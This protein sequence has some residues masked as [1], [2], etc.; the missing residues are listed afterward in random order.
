MK[1]KVLQNSYSDLLKERDLDPKEEFLTKLDSPHQID[2]LQVYRD[3]SLEVQ[4]KSLIATFR[5]TY[6]YLEDE[7]FRALSRDYLK[8][9]YSDK[10]LELNFLGKNLPAFI[11]QNK[12][13][14]DIL[15]LYETACVDW[16]CHLIFYGEDI[17]CALVSLAQLEHLCVRENNE[18]VT[19]TGNDDL[20]D[21]VS[22]LLDENED[23]D[24]TKIEIS[25]NPKESILVR[26]K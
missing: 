4:I 5:L 14:D 21:V 11:R 13:V 6:E 25:K 19:I 10:K 22:V 1:W 3:S 24:F 23:W 17:T 18:C 7:G 26:L 16:L 15:Y 2:M 9:E 20:I 12:E 8:S